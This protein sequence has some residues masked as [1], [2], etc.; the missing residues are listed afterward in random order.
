MTEDRAMRNPR[1]SRPDGV[2]EFAPRRLDWR[3]VAIVVATIAG[4]VA[5]IVGLVW[6]AVA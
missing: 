6:W 5:G 4:V 3:C 2:D 1:Y